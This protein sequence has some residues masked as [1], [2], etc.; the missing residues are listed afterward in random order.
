MSVTVREVHVEN[1]KLMKTLQR[2]AEFVE[3]ELGC[4]M[5][6]IIVLVPE[7][8]AALI[9][10]PKIQENPLHTDAICR[11]IV[12]AANAYQ[13]VNGTAPRA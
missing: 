12:I 7:G 9:L 6:G 4:Q 2:A 10:H 5:A 11:E 13:K 1:G 3:K 8:A